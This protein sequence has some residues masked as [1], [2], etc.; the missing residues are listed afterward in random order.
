M[1]PPR[2]LPLKSWN[3][4]MARTATR[5]GCAL[6]ADLRDLS[7]VAP[8]EIADKLLILHTADIASVPYPPPRK[9]MKSVS[10]PLQ[11][12]PQC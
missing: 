11:G 1:P 7:P 5:R 9:R 12:Y 4:A 2:V 6:H 8:R 3:E 10:W